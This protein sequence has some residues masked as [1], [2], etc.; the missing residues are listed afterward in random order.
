MALWYETGNGMVKTSFA[1]CDLGLDVYLCCPGPSLSNIDPQILQ[2]PGIFVVAINSAYPYIKPNLWLGMDG[3]NC[4]NQNLLDEPFIKVFRGGYQFKKTK[5]NRIL[6]DCPNSY[7]ADCA[8]PTSKEELFRLRAHDVKFVWHKNTL[9]ITL[10]ILVWMGAKNIHLLGCDLGGD[11]DYHHD[12]T[13]TNKQR[14]YNQK[15]YGKQKEYLKWFSEKGKEHSIK[16]ISCSPNSPINE[17]LPFHQ[18]DLAATNSSRE[19]SSNFCHVLDDP[20]SQ[21]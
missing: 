9:A 7:F 1:R 11:K 20:D 18:I 2:K 4:Y 12:L 3:P 16:L 10:H 5:N 13:L 6:K 19:I 17:F 8:V 14:E 21:T 15:L